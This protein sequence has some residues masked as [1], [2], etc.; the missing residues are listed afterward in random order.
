MSRW[1]MASLVC[2]GLV[3]CSGGDDGGD[4]TGTVVG[5][6]EAGEQVFLDNCA[7]C[8]SDDGSGGTGNDIRGEDDEAEIAATV[9]S[10]VG[11]MPAFADT[12][13][14]QEIAD[15]AAYVAQIL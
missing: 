7:I 10:G 9:E 12:L 5:D 2:V 3:A 6:P 13:T 14:E 1:M 11:S 8:H 15:V 4:G